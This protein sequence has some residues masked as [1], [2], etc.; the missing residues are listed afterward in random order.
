MISGPSA[1]SGSKAKISP[2]RWS[3]KR[4][5]PLGSNHTDLLRPSWARS[6]PQRLDIIA[7]RSSPRPKVVRLTSSTSSGSG[8]VG[9]RCGGTG[10]EST[11]S[12]RGWS[13]VPRTRT[14]RGGWEWINALVT[15]SETP[16]W[17][18]STRSSRPISE[19]ILDTQE[20][21]SFTEG[22]LAGSTSERLFRGTVLAPVNGIGQPGWGR[23]SR[24]QQKIRGMGPVRHSCAIN[25]NRPV[26]T[27][28]F[29]RLP[30]ST[31]GS[32]TD[33]V[34]FGRLVCRD[35]CAC[36]SGW[37]SRL[38]WGPMTC[39]PSSCC[40]SGVARSF[41]YCSPGRALH[42]PAVGDRRRSRGRPS[43]ARRP[44]RGPPGWSA[45]RRRSAA[46]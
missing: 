40:P 46:R 23:H 20:R 31:D 25:F 45:R 2:S 16:S 32:S 26:S 11:T 12:M 42:R 10:E 30:P 36:T 18:A 44:A 6:E 28:H 13:T 15:S 43:G 19:R 38:A 22:G 1:R 41:T 8:A 24:F 4:A 37:S 7:T 33:F 39:A 14:D 29:R 9:A 34:P 21:A 27:G 17:A 5:S 3:S 35:S